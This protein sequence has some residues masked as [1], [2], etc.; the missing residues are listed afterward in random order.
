MSEEWPTRESASFEPTEETQIVPPQ[1]G[2]APPPPPL[3]EPTRR[4]NRGIVGGLLFLVAAIVVLVIVLATGRPHELSTSPRPDSATPAMHTTT[5][6]STTTTTT[7]ATTTTPATATVPSLS[8]K[9]QSALQQLRNAGFQASVAY[10]PSSEPSGTVVAQSPAGGATA[11]ASSHVTVNVS[12]G[13]AAGTEQTV[14]NTIGMTIP[15]AVA[16][17]NQAGLRLV[18][19]RRP[20]TDQSQGGKVVA[21]TPSAGAHAPKSSQV[22]VYMGAYKGA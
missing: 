7:A 12:S 2:S 13:Q 4:L 22:L 9:L 8:G 19:L 1:P 5:A 20:V 18:M 21:Q 14:P 17:V 15:D 6:A 10:V 3:E 16:A 11:P